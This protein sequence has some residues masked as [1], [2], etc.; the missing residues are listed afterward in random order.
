MTR[1]NIENETE[2]IQRQ[3]DEF[4]ETF[5]HSLNTAVGRLWSNPTFHV[6]QRTAKKKD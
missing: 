4:D 5:S 1:K 2:N 6:D 3:N